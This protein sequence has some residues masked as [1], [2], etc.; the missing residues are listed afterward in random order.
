MGLGLGTGWHKEK[1]P[2]LKRLAS[3]AGFAIF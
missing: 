2:G 1:Y 3:R